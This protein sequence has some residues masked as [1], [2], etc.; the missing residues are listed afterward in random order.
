[1][2]KITKFYDQTPSDRVIGLYLHPYAAKKGDILN[3]KT[4][5]PN[6][7]KPASTSCGFT[8]NA[9]KNPTTSLICN[10]AVQGSMLNVQCSMLKRLRESKGSP[11]SSFQSPARAATPEP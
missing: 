9:S 1:M 5:Q 10:A 4:C 6:A 11:M 2:P 3:F 8:M 7:T